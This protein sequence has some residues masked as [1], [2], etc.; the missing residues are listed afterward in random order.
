MHPDFNTHITK[1]IKTNFTIP[2]QCKTIDMKNPVYPLVLLV[3]TLF[4]LASCKENTFQQLNIIPKP[5]SAYATHK[6]ITLDKNSRI[7]YEDPNPAL[8]L[9]GE[10]LAAFIHS[11][12]DFRPEV[13][14][15]SLIQSLE[16]DIFLAT[17]LNDSS[18]GNDGYRISNSGGKIIS[19]Q[20]NGGQGVFYGIQS[21]YQLFPIEF[22]QA[23]ESKSSWEV[24]IVN[25][26][27]KSRFAYRG[28]HLDVGRHLFP[29]EF[30]KQYIDLM[31]LYKYNYFHWHLTEDQGWRIE[32]KGYPNLTKTG[33]WRSETIM[34]HQSERPKNFD[35]KPYGGFY[36]QDEVREIVDYAASRYITVI[37]EIE[38]PGHSSAA[39]AAYPEL[40]CSGGPY[41]VQTQWGVF[42][43]IYCTKESTF[44]F[45]EAVLTEVMALF[46]GKYIHIGGDEAP[47]KSWK[48]C[49]HCQETIREE[50]LENEA[51]LQS[52]FITR[53]ADFLQKNDRQL[54][55]WDEILE[56]G[57]P[58]DATVMS[59]RGTEGGIAAAQ[60]G[61]DVI[62][63]PGSHC[64][65]DHYQGNSETEP[66]AIG[67][68]TPV[69]KVYAYEAIPAELNQQEARHILG[70]Q[71]NVWTEY[72]RNPDAVT[73]M[74]LPRMAALSEALWSPPEKKDWKS[75]YDRLPAHFSR[76]EALGLKYSR[77]VD[78]AKIQITQS[79]TGEKILEISSEIPEA[80]IYYT[81]NPS[82][83]GQSSQLYQ[84]AFDP[85]KAE[86]IS[87][88]LFRN[89]KP[90]GD[91]QIHSLNY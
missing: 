47:K 57:L 90:V 61:H 51:E 88:Q 11:K 67:G 80:S 91:P 68:Y 17:N 24:P 33:A 40:G 73:Y 53:I 7:I 87:I 18:F 32:I 83:P 55:G 3:T 74:I 22:Y 35:G 72:L 64:Y 4:L 20:A 70:A 52:W 12:S 85:K 29:V 75:F 63:T 21:F 14:P 44:T 5:H 86:S 15:Y 41:Q 54:I 69:S 27:D 25:I 50:G 62:M 48:N 46:P 89:E 37:P 39:L 2:V 23:T 13:V 82:I 10:E 42:D 1:E 16:N 59:W 28:M 77:A 6:N 19:I 60:M 71:A 56:G 78:Q 76:Y 81:L 34:G 36:T 49:P 8:R 84:Q 66:L 30:I 58:S 26:S 31:A 9:M 79:E 65:F 38:M 45:L 43:E